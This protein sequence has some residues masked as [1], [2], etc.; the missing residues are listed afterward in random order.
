VT[1]SRTLARILLGLPCSVALAAPPLDAQEVCPRP[2][3]LTETVRIGSIDGPDALTYPVVLETGPD[4]RVYLIQSMISAV[5]IFKSDGTPDRLFGRAGAG[6]GEFS[7]FPGSV[8]WTDTTLWVRDWDQIHLYSRDGSHLRTVRF[9][10]PVPR[11]GSVFVPG[12]PL[13]DGSFLGSRLVNDYNRF[14]ARPFLPVLRFSETGD[15]LDTIARVDRRGRFV[16]Y[17]AANGWTIN[18]E[19]PLTHYLNVPGENTL[20]AG[21]PA[22]DGS[23]VI[24]VEPP[25]ERAAGSSFELLHLGLDGDTLLRRRIEYDPI[26]IRPHPDHPCSTGPAPRVVRRLGGARVHATGHG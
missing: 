3:P 13:S 1:R 2:W 20:T 7:R 26:P 12:R 19:H 11:E 21:V 17:E 5:S 8:G 9:R 10:I 18:H 4:G 22:H 16:P 23:G 14:A 24:V 25:R 15:V 6:P